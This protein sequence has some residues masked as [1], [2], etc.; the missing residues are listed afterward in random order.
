MRLI[1]T[2]G[3][4]KTT[5]DWPASLK[6]NDLDQ[7]IW[8]EEL[9][10][11]V[12]SRVFDIHTHVYRW[13]FNTDPHKDSGPDAMVCRQFP[14]ST[15]AAL[16]ACD[17]TLMPGR[18][19]HRLA[20]PFPF[21]SSCD[22]AASNQFVAEESRHDSNSGALM[23]VHPSM[24][25]ERIEAQLVKHCFLGFKP[26]R[27]YSTTGDADECRITDF[28]PEHQIELA[29]QHHLIIMLHMAKRRG[30]ADLQNIED[31]ERFSQ[32]YPNV[33]WVL[34]HCARSYSAWAI[35]KAANRLRQ[36]PNIWYETS[37]VCESDAIEALIAGVGPE[38]VMYGSDDIPVGVSRGKYIAF[39]YAWAY[40][41][42]TNHSCDLSHCDGR[43]TFVR[44]EQ[45]RAMRRA[46]I[47]L[48]LSRQQIEDLFHN[49]AVQLRGSTRTD[50]KSG[51]P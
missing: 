37:S 43:M 7:H 13:E 19:V 28:L 5:A 10:P 14:E 33:K 9:D 20:F 11:F 31:L 50:A 49:T 3:T 42:E 25:A 1:K 46:A 24:T 41:S 45:L 29:H 17:A 8:D 15:W 48:G 35:E 12:P 47:R 51:I 2:T 4:D 40:L 38:R 34:A 18:Q 22:F 26:Y 27:F 21:R 39:G 30:I 16:D 44:Y 36:L 23:L 32:E 6:L